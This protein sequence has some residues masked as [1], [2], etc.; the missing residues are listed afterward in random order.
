MGNFR[1][2]GSYDWESFDHTHVVRLLK[3][4][5]ETKYNLRTIP[6][7][8]KIKKEAEIA[9]KH[10]LRDSHPYVAHTPD[11]IIKTGEELEDR[12]FIEYVNTQG[13][14]DSQFLFDLRGMIALSRLMKARGFVV[15]IRHNISP[16]YSFTKLPVS[17][18]VVVM[19]LKSLLFALDKGALGYLC[20]EDLRKKQS[21]SPS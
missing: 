16:K 5:I 17:S 8:R 1:G 15:A 20:D 7:D 9:V 2:W 11:I 4:I 21:P 12:I 14:N 13:T 10:G 19:S 3:K 6:F 18:Y